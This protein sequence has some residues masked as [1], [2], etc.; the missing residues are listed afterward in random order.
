MIVGV[1]GLLLAWWFYIRKPAIPEKLAKDIHG[2]YELLLHKYWVD[3]LYAL[4]F[5]RPLLW[6]STNVLWHVI[7]EGMIDGVVNG[8]ASVARKFGGEVRELQSG[9]TRSYAT[10]VVVGAVGFTVLLLTL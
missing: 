1:L 2:P 9:N 6:I 8:T 4:I 10:W 3:E 5:V 7:D